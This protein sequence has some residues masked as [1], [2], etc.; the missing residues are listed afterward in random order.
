MSSLSNKAKEEFLSGSNCAQ[1]VISVF[2]EKYG[3]DTNIALA[4]T[5]GF[6]GGMRSGEICGAVSGAIAVI[7]LANAKK[8]ENSDSAKLATRAKTME[9][10]KAFKNKYDELVCRKL[11]TGGRLNCANYVAFAVESLE[12]MGY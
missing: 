9:L 7:G 2:C 5:D 6:G 10:T 8:C 11:I 3:L 12:E 4:L 1:A